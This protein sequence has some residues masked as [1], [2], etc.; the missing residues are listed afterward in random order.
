MNRSIKTLFFAAILFLQ[1]NMISAQIKTADSLKGKTVKWEV[2][3]RK[4]NEFLLYMPQGYKTVSDGNFITGKPGVGGRVDRK[5]IVYRYI[6]GV[7]LMMEYFEGDAKLIQKNLQE[8]E[9]STVEKSEIINGFEFEQFVG[10]S[11]N[12]STKAQYFRIKNR[13]YI[14]KAIAKSADN[15]IF[16]G[17]F[18]SVK[19]VENKKVVSPNVPANIT[20]ITLPN[21]VEQEA[22]RIGD[23]AAIESKQA[24]RKVIVLYSPRPK[25]PRGQLGRSGGKSN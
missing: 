19:L 23:D 9:K 2:L 4:D 21:I 14:L 8:R 25:Y 20:A 24:D 6:N 13:L 22:D 12:Y 18:K 7:V 1:I 5:L 17:F 10:S 3:S 11:G 15:P 16:E